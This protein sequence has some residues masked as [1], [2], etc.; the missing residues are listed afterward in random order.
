MT[1]KVAN[2]GIIV[3]S[4]ILGGIAANNGYVIMG[5]ILAW[6]SGAIFGAIRQRGKGGSL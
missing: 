1:D 2:A 3:L 5:V 4:F 6:M